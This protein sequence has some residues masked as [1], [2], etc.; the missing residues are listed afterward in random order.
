MPKYLVTFEKGE[1]VRWLGHLDI[2][3]TFE[4]AIRRARLPIAFSAGFNP[5]ER[6]VFASALAT[7]VTGAAEPVLVELTCEQD[8][9]E[10]AGALNA[11][12]PP[13]IRIRECEFVPDDGSR[14]LVHRFVRA[15]YEIICDVPPG[16]LDAAGGAARLMQR[17]SIPV[18]RE[19]EGR[20]K[21]VDI[22]PFVYSLSVCECSADPPS[23]L[24]RMVVALGESG[25]AKP[26]EVAAALAEE[27][28]GLHPRRTHRL[29][30][31]YADRNGNA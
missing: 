21:S 16:T 3:R 8:T 17:E 10:I 22:R 30:L 27:I 18:V 13:G 9:V 2:L 20:R 15:E 1:P 25:A 24:V 7:G 6:L 4:R 29:R 19:R 5:R 23:V 28:A 26:A 14:D 31:L 12:L 11:V